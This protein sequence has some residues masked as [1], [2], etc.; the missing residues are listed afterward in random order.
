MFFYFIIFTNFFISA[1]SSWLHSGT[2]AEDNPI[3]PVQMISVTVEGVWVSDC[4]RWWSLGLGVQCCC[5]AWQMKMKN[6][7]ASKRWWVP[8]NF[9]L[10]SSKGSLLQKRCSSY[11]ETATSSQQNHP[12]QTTWRP[13]QRLP[14]WEAAPLQR[15]N[16]FA[17]LQNFGSLDKRKN[18]TYH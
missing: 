2:A 17:N 5:L 1:M 14:I 6:I 3:T 4:Q 9:E 15:H 18:I 13:H 16:F 8:T 12:G 10:A 7:V 11:R